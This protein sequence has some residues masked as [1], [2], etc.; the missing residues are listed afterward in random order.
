MKPSAL[1]FLPTRSTFMRVD[2]KILG[3]LYHLKTAHLDQSASKAGYLTRVLGAM[4]L[5]LVSFKA[6]SIFIWFADYHSA[7][8]VWLAK[9][10]GKKSYIF[11][12]GYDAKK[13]PE[14]GMGVHCSRFRSRCAAFALKNC[15]HIIANHESLLSSDNLY[16]NPKGH[17]E[18]IY[19]LVPGL[20]TPATVIHNAVTVD[21]PDEFRPRIKQILTVGTTPVFQAFCNKGYDLL[22]EIAR[23]RPDL[24]FVFVGIQAKWMDEIDRIYGLA[25]LSNLTVHHHLGQTELFALMQSSAVYAQPSIS[26]GLPNA[27]MEAMLMGC[28]PVG[29][30]VA[31]IPTVIGDHGFLLQRHDSQELESLLDRALALDPDRRAISE[32]IKTR[33]SL[34]KRKAG[35][36]AVLAE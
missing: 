24:Q 10:L 34:E 19:R 29:S 3:S 22:V 9:L 5:L 13:Y 36:I 26:E 33:F 35:L 14:F 31:G 2:E 12:A 23:R 8:L 7:P 21:P 16:Y 28:V 6:E 17:P 18:G 15:T 11:I 30:R 20:S 25:G 1:L 4:A 32:S 27:L